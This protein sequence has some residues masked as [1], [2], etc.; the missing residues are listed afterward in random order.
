MAHLWQ[1]KAELTAQVAR[2]SLSFSPSLPF[3]FLL[4]L[5]YLGATSLPYKSVETSFPRGHCTVRALSIHTLRAARF[6]SPATPP[7]FV[8][9]R[10]R[11]SP[12]IRPLPQRFRQ[13]T[14]SAC[15]CCTCS[16]LVAW[17]VNFIWPP[18]FI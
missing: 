14:V 7:P 17:C 18:F 15:C 6:L 5:L 1:A 8:C 12:P 2:L 11:L 13:S 9:A 4:L 10:A 3:S 16:I